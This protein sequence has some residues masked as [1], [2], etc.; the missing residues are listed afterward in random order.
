MQ[1]LASLKLT[2]VLLLW[3]LAAVWIAYQLEWSYH[4]SGWGVWVLAPVMAL[5]TINLLAAIITNARFRRQPALLVFHISLVLIVLLVGLGRLLHLKGWVEVTTGSEFTG[6]LTQYEAGPWHPGHFTELRFINEGFDIHYSPGPRRGHTYNRMRWRDQQGR[7]HREV[8]GDQTPLQIREYRFYTS[9]NKGFAPTFIWKAHGEPMPQLGVVHLPA[10]PENTFSQA[11]EWTPPGASQSIWF[12]L[13]FDEV[14][15]KPETDS[16]F[17]APKDHKLVVRIGEGRREIGPGE[18][19]LL[20]D[21]ILVYQGLNTWMGYTVYYDPTRYWLL[22]ACLM[23]I[24]SIGVFFWQ[25]FSRIPWV[26]E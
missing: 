14:I 13:V 8:I 16:V 5:L 2:L 20:D 11:Q 12:K 7:E 24:G 22:A 18:E 9:F 19:L 23:A 21:G 3:L 10:Y 6:Q 4:V 15:L 1:R 17:H 25:K 26:K